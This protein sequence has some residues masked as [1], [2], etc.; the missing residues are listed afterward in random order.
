MI[1][2]AERLAAERGLAGLTVQ[3]VQQAAGQRNNSAVQYHFGGRQGLVDALIADRMGPTEQRRASM[4][5]ALGDDATVRDLVGVTVAPLVESVLSRRPSYWARFLLQAISDPAT[6]LTALAAADGEALQAA[7]TRLKARLPHLPEAT[8]TL[9]V[10]STF[11]Y[12]CVLLAA[13]EIDALPPELTGDALVTEVVDAC[14]GL[15]DAPS[16]HSPSETQR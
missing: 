8:R 11:G 13:Y 6:A 14:C 15:V 5:L 4:L 10:Q 9:R 12:A 1:D 7:Q 2:A 3:A 16:T